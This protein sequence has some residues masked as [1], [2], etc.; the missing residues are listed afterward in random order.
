MPDFSGNKAICCPGFVRLG[1]P[2]V[3]RAARF[4]MS[5]AVILLGGPEAWAETR[6]PADSHIAR[7]NHAGFKTRGYCTGF[8]TQEGPVITAAHCLPEIPTDIVHVLLG[9][10]TG[11]LE[12][13]I[14]TP[15]TSYRIMPGHDIAALCDIKGDP[16]GLR[17]TDAWRCP[18][19][20]YT[21]GGA[22]L[23]RAERACA[24][25]DSNRPVRWRGLSLP[26]ENLMQLDCPLPPG[27]SGA[28]VTLTGSGSRDVVGVVSASST[29]GSFAYLLSV[30][31]TER[32][33]K[34]DN[35]SALASLSSPT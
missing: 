5:L 31:M 29:T 13:H 16:N 3:R 19:A 20:G 33:C 26:L 2:A 4:C 11:Q 23:R 7:L 27:T 15:A 34:D 18:N 6:V 21:G 35:T 25:E 1:R 10:E 14:K 9:Y 22:G 17:L 8:A 30:D 32:L 28:P 24:A 12:Q